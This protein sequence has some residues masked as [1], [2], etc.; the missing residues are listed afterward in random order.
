MPDGTI[1]TLEAVTSGKSRQQFEFQVP[2]P[3]GGLRGWWEGPQKNGFSAHAADGDSIIWLSRRDPSSGAPLG[4]EWWQ[5]CIALDEHG[6]EIEDHHAGYHALGVGTNASVSGSRPFAPL[7]SRPYEKIV[8][9]SSFRPFRNAAP[10]FKLRVYDTSDALVAEFD[11]P[12]PATGSIPVWQPE[13]LPST[14]QAGD[15]SV[16]LKQLYF[17]PTKF[18]GGSALM[19][20]VLPKF[21]ILRGGE[22]TTDWSTDQLFILDPLGNSQLV[23][24][25]NLC[26]QEAAWKLR[27]QL[28]RKETAPFDA[29]ET[30]TTSPVAVPATDT[31]RAITGRSV[32]QG[33]TLESLVVG[34][35]GKTSFVL[36]GPSSRGGGSSSTRGGA[37]GGE[38][39]IRIVSEAGKKTITAQSARPYLM[40]NVMG[41][42]PDIRLTVRVSDAQGRPGKA[43]SVGSI[44][45]LQIW[46]LTV[47]PGDPPF[48]FTFIVQKAR[49]VEFLIAPP[50]VPEPNP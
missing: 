41:I 11:A 8:A 27:L 25:C 24:G 37:E 3:K 28:F 6:C 20:R 9:T 10:T 7:P 26:P 17:E 38:Y 5:S 39:E 12:T 40:A 35:P 2:N 4:F 13:P 29:T 19:L 22:P 18:N 16:T 46:M 42:D 34:G 43:Q 21:E 45:N 36:L 15:L 49:T 50:Q 47:P 14:K 30:W 44:Q 32:V 23:W 31:A 48:E 1:L 33:V